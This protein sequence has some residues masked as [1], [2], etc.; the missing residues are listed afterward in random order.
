MIN[1]DI[2]I[3]SIISI[4]HLIRLPFLEGFAIGVSL[5]MLLSGEVDDDSYCGDQDGDANTHVPGCNSCTGILLFF[6][7]GGG[8]WPIGI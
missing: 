1:L 8:F 6:W 3:C 4:H 2:C 7:G 5:F